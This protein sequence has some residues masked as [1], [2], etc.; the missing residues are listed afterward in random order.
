MT[1]PYYLPRDMYQGEARNTNLGEM[2]EELERCK[3]GITKAIEQL[4]QL[5]AWPEV[6]PPA[7]LM[8]ATRALFTLKELQ[9]ARR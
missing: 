7:A 4:E 3:A 8:Q 9:R 1:T 2:A 5:K 6:V